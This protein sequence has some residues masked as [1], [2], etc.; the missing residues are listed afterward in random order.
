MQFE[1]GPSSR[2]LQSQRG[3]PGGVTP[4]LLLF[5]SLRGPPAPYRS[6]AHACLNTTN[7]TNSQTPMAPSVTNQMGHGFARKM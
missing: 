5:V 7:L 2:G 1:G 3:R 6:G 4:G